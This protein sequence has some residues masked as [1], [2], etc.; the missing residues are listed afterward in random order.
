MAD[1]ILIVKESIMTPDNRPYWITD[2]LVSVSPNNFSFLTAT[3]AE[4]FFGVPANRLRWWLWKEREKGGLTL[5]GKPFNLRRSSNYRVFNIG[6]VEKLAHA[7]AQ[8]GHIDGDRLSKIIL[9]VKTH[10]QLA[11]MPL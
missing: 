7:L 11:G 9:M 5:D 8:A 3:V 4:V 6:D 2:E 1:R 10:A